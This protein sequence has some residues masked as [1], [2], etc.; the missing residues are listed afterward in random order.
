MLKKIIQAYYKLPPAAA[1]VL[2]YFLYAVIGTSLLLLPACYKTELP[3]LDNIFTAV[4]AISSTG[5]L[6]VNIAATYTFF[7]QLIILIL[8]Q[9]G[10]IGYMTISSFV[11]LTTTNAR[12]SYKTKIMEAMLPFPKE[13]SPR[14]FLKNVII[15]TVICEVIGAITLSILFKN[16]GIEDYIWNGIFHSISAFCTAGFTLF[17]DSIVQFRFDVSINFVLS[18]LCILGSLGFIVFHDVYE[19]FTQEKRRLTFTSKIILTVTFSFLLFGTLIFFFLERPYATGNVYQQL[20]IAFF[21]VMSSSTTVGFSTIDLGTLQEPTLILLL[22]LMLFGASPSGTGGGVK[23]TTFAALMALVLNTM[24]GRTFVSLWKR[25]IPTKRLQLATAMFTYYMV[26]LT[27][28]I[29][30]LS[31]FDHSPFLSV[32]FEA[33]AT[34]GTVGLSTGITPDLTVIGKSISILLMFMGRVGILMFGFAI[35]SQRHEP[36]K[37]KRDNELVF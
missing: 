27:V 37:Y 5:Q 36:I 21:Q 35:M 10:S 24:K 28:A 32:V 33:A 2:D 7:G 30:F 26:V 1:F 3:L 22:S 8:M 12:P 13:F 6:T 19:K 31:L 20:M 17:S 16:R 14:A 4:S 11:I 18:L 34:L 15:F 25:E 9:I 23:S 29:F